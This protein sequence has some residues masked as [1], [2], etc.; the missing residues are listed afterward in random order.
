MISILTP[1][2]NRAYI[3][4]KAYQSLCEQTSF[5]FEWIIIDD[6]STDNTEELVSTWKK[7]CALFPI[8]YY[9]QQNGGKHRALNK[10]VSFVNSKYVLILDSDD[11]LGDNAVKLIHEWVSS[12]EGVSAFA[13]V[14]GLKAWNNKEGVVGGLIKKDYID[15]TNLERRK[16]GLL[17]DKA[18]VYKTEILKKY[19][20]PE[21]EGENFLRESASWDRIAYDGYKIRWFNTVIY[22][23]DYLNDGLTKNAG[24]KL[25]AKNF[26][27]F[28]YCTKLHIL[29]QPGLYK[30]LKIG[31][32]V[33]VAKLKQIKNKEI[34]KLLEIKPLQVFLGSIVYKSNRIIK[35]MLGKK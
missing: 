5:E 10:G 29:V 16:Y 28:T 26:N 34:C 30:Y 20:F 17:G 15:A 7:D 11:S 9:K 3:L 8:I 25:Y 6:G 4:E 33:K 19:P 1:T 12:I 13:G 24:E 23:C 22:R 35:K 32:Y 18:E 14:A 27:G 2:Y 31:Y 21:F